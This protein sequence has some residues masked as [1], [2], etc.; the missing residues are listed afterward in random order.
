MKKFFSFCLLVGMIT[1]FQGCTSIKEIDI[2]K[3]IEI[4]VDGYQGYGEINIT[5][6][7]EFYKDKEI[8]GEG[9]INYSNL[10]NY[11]VKIVSDKIEMLSNDDVISLSLQYD[12]EIYKNDLKVKLNNEEKKEYK[13][14]GLSKAFMTQNDLTNNDYIKLKDETYDKVKKYVDSTNKS[15]IKYG[16]IEFIDGFI[17][18]PVKNIEESGF[19]VP[20]LVYLYKVNKTVEYEYIRPD[21]T[22]NYIFVTVSGITLDKE[23]KLSDYVIP[24]VG[25]SIFSDD[26]KSYS[27]DKLPD[28]ESIK[29]DYLSTND[30]LEKL[31][32]SQ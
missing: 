5:L 28:L 10:E 20:E 4:S 22:V 32:I 19:E 6:N 18:N 15:N 31:N 7:N 2:S 9:L 30:V 8:F 24:D 12:E 29:A 14:S 16:D 1:L 11:N 26:I 13:V 3:Y 23:G 27:I 17:K 25:G 21:N